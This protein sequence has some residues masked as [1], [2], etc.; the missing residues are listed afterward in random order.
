LILLISRVC[1]DTELGANLRV[2]R[3][4]V[5]RKTA[6][7]YVSA[8][9]TAESESAEKPLYI[10]LYWCSGYSIHLSCRLVSCLRNK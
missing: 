2:A 7:D 9:S 1:Q 3:A 8:V 6:T 10:Q 4:I 5:I